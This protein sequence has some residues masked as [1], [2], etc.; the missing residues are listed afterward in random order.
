MTDTAF[1]TVT[2]LLDGFASGALSPVAVMDRYLEQIA[3]LDDK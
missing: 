1:S 3:T 2:E